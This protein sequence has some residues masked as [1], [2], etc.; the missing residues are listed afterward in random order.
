MR[1]SP[2]NV[3]MFL[4]RRRTEIL[5]AGLPVLLA[6][7]I[8]WFLLRPSIQNILHCRELIIEKETLLKRYQERLEELAQKSPPEPGNS[9]LG[10]LFR[11]RDPYV[12][13]SSL[14]KEFESIPEI[15]VR[16]FRVLS[17]RPF[18][19]GGIK[20]VEINFDLEGD[21]KGLAELLERL[22]NHEKALRVK[23]LLV[24]QL[25]R[26]GVPALRISLRLEAPFQVES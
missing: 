24:S 3:L 15:S 2:E 18:R 12:I 13:V 5:L 9:P 17:Q 8:F 6:L 23:Y 19:D 10:S 7:F 4:R 25:V 14:Q 22:E 11:G 21:I 20:L 26:R 1:I 16:S